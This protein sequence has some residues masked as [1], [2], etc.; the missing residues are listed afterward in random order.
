MKRVSG[1]EFQAAR[2]RAAA[3]PETRNSRLVVQDIRKSYR[4][5]AGRVIE[6]LRGVSFAVTAGEMVAVMGASGTGKSTLLHVLGGLE[7][8]DDGR[9][10]LDAFDITRAEDA[11]LARFRRQEVG[12]I[13]QFH[14]LLRGLTAAENIAMPLLI[15][16]RPGR[17]AHEAALEMLER[18][19]LRERAAHNVSEL[20]GGEQQRVAIA[21]ALVSAPRLVLADEPTGNLDAQTGETIG[22]LLLALCRAGR[23]SVVI[24]THN[25][26]LARTCDRTLLLQNG[27]VE[28]KTRE[29]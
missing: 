25:E 16:R 22:A 19:G 3:E 24:A 28:T 26:D 23:V 18:V 7:A 5:P 4:D 8:A 14:H 13:F 20:S 27:R 11:E 9:A 21:R 29:R 6:V 2:L 12:F 15:A 17:A 10:Q 1:F